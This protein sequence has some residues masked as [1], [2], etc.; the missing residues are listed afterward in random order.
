MRFLPGGSAQPAASA[1][2]L[3]ATPATAGSLPLS[4][5]FRTWNNQAEY[6][7]ATHKR[8]PAHR[9]TE[10]L[11]RRRN[12]VPGREEAPFSFAPLWSEL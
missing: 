4:R 3:H 5:R 6:R 12:R 7:I 10:A 9:R 8:D 11:L 1:S 2:V